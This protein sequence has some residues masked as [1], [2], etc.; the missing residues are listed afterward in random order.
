ML[1]IRLNAIQLKPLMIRAFKERNLNETSANHI[2]SSI[3][4]TSLRGVDSHGINLFPHYCRSVV[5]GRIN[6]QPQFSYP[7]LHASA[8]VLDADHAAGHHSGIVAIEKCMELANQTGVGTVAVRNSSHFGA[9]AYFALHAAE[10]GY[11]AFSFTNADALVKAFSAKTAFFGTNPVCMAAPMLNEE[12]FCLDMATSLVSW[13]KIRN[14]RTANADIPYGWAYNK[15][16]EFVTNPHEATSLEPAG[17]YKGFGLGMMVDI[18]CALLA[19]GPIS[20]DILPMFSSAPEARREIGHFFIVFSI[21]HFAE[22]EYFSQ[23]LQNMADR[24]R[25]LEPHLTGER[26]MV[27]GDPEKLAFE[28]NQTQG[29]H[30][31]HEKFAEF[32]EISPDFEYTKI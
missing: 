16:G 29:V 27:P 1:P 26:V 31:D 14:Y 25:S 2:V 9:A 11:L 3:L 32:L 17:G 15:E 28:R 13:N 6:A 5:S 10:K 23:A 21:K 4:Q 20:K 24:I 7:T 19:S 30:V 8:A 18:L 12:P 22:P